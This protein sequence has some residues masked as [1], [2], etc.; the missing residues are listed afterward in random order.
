M[1]VWVNYLKSPPSLADS[2][3]GLFSGIA[4]AGA[5]LAPLAGQDDGI[6][7]ALEAQHLD[8]RGVELVVLSACD[9]SLGSGTIGEGMLGMQR[10]FQ[11]A[12]AR[13]RSARS[14]GWTT[15]PRRF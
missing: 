11:V 15:P 8:L 3:P 10:A 2:S 6:I 7:T 4:L 14:G 9:T 5:D 1:N 13:W 12:G